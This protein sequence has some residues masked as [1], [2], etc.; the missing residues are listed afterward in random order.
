MTVR[1]AGVAPSRGLLNPNKYRSLHGLATLDTCL[2]LTLK[3]RT[4]LRHKP[5]V[6]TLFL[7]IEAGCDNVDAPSLTSS[8]LNRGIPSYML[9]WIS[10]VLCERTCTLYSKAAPTCW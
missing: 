5:L 10:S 2:S 7:D 1:L 4:F 9:H 6:S 8:L 3:V